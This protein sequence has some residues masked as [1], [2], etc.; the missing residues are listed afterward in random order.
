MIGREIE[1]E[2]EKKV[3]VKEEWE[4]KVRERE[5]RRKGDGEHSIRRGG[6][7]KLLMV[8][9]RPTIKSYNSNSIT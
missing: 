3:R 2:R 1:Q 5:E 4:E 6:T 9:N 7:A 8:D